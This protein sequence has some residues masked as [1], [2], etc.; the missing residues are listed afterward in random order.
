MAQQSYQLRIT[1][2]VQ[3]V[4]F[5]AFTQQQAQALG[6]VGFVQNESDGSVYAEVSGSEAACQELIQ[7]LRRGPAVSRVDHIEVQD[8]GARSYSSF[9]INR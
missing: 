9:T 1:G 4:G 8:T 7:R 2:K 6:L 5:R 3:G